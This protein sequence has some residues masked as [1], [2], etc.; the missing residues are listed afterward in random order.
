MLLISSRSAWTGGGKKAF[1]SSFA[2]SSGLLIMVSPS[3]RAGRHDC[4]GVESLDHLVFFYMFWGDSHASATNARNDF[5]I[6]FLIR[7]VL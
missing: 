1:I 6:A 7:L 4:L 5:F 2:L 3:L